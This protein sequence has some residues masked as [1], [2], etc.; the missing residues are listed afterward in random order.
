M[1]PQSIVGMLEPILDN[2]PLPLLIRLLPLS[3]RRCPTPRPLFST[4]RP[5]ALAS[6]LFALKLIK[7][8]NDVPFN[9]PFNRTHA[10]FLRSLPRFRSLCGNHRQ[11]IVILIKRVRA[12]I[13]RLVILSVGKR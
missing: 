7:A 13:Q 10:L 5:S 4:A 12:G 2:L 1:E 8:L 3:P 11:G 6:S 9:L